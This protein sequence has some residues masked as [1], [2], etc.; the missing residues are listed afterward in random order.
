MSILE[1]DMVSL[2]LNSLSAHEIAPMMTSFPYFNVGVV[3]L[4]GLQMARMN[5]L[6][7]AFCQNCEMSTFPAM[8]MTSVGGLVKVLLALVLCHKALVVM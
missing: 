8:H 3:W 2:E 4:L 6:L 7:G 1:T 5:H